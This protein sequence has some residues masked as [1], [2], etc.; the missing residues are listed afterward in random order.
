MSPMARRKDVVNIVEE[1]EISTADNGENKPKP[2]KGVFVP[3]DNEGNLDLKRVRDPEGIDAA[4]NALGV[5]APSTAVAGTPGLIT[6]E[7]VK[8]ALGYYQY[9]PT[10]TIVPFINRPLRENGRPEISQELALRCYTL[11]EEQ[12]ASAAPDGAQAINQII[13]A[14]PQWLKDFLFSFGPGAKFLGQLAMF[15]AFQTQRMLTIYKSQ[16]PPEQP[17]GTVES[18]PN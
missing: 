2:R 16:N 6:E 3:F 5:V 17:I 1:P 7:Q 13:D 9:L 4:R 10:N 12:I 18:K 14:L 8:F 15:T 11:S